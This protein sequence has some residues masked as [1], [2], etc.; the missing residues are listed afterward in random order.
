MA[1]SFFRE[2]RGVEIMPRVAGVAAWLR[3][4]TG[5][6]RLLV[7][8][9]LGAV[10]ALAYAP[11]YAWP[12]LFLAFPA[13][14]FIIDG[15]EGARR[16]WFAAGLGG[17][18]FGFG[19]FLVGL[20]WVG[21]AFVVDAERH[22]WLLPFVAVLFP[23]GLALFFAAAA[24]VARLRWSAG[25]AR[26]ALLAAC[27]AV[28]EWLRGHIL[29]GFPWNLPGYAWSGFDA[30]LQAASVFGV[31]GLSLLTLVAAL[32]PAAVFDA[33]GRRSRLAWPL[34]GPAAILVALFVFG[35]MRLPSVAAP[36]FPDV[37]LRIVQPNIPQ[38]EKWKPDLMERNWRTLLDLTRS[39]G[40]E[41]RTVVIWTEAAPPFLLLAEPLGLKVIAEVLPDRATLLTG[42]VR[43]EE[44]DGKRRFFNSMAAVSGEGRVLGVYDKSHLVPFGEYLPFYQWLEPLGI[45]K[46]TGGSGGYTQGSGVRT[47]AISGTPSFGPLICYEV[48]FPGAVIEPGHR[49]D[50]LVTMTDDSWFGPWTGPYQ[51][52]GIAKVRAAEEGLAI[53]RAAN[54]GVSAVIDPYGRIIS[55]LG[56]DKTGFL[57]AA[58]P[59]PLAPT[60]YSFVGDTIFAA[61]LL[62]LAGAGLFFYRSTSQGS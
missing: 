26:I 46:L 27:L 1:S 15:T 34:I 6:R 52:L 47:L 50:W 13:L 30:M 57:D 54:T 60:V 10:C 16:P 11:F 62:A 9:S 5:V 35:W 41:T 7:A 24:A 20:H 22:A 53:V 55:S 45:T 36:V 25:L 4:L 37:A 43:S 2:L 51:H 14:V 21:F 59:K 8:A 12:V 40:L 39:P 38:S 28:V 58:L 48:I 61:L 19:Y 56:L 18:A 3:R 31:Y 33:D 29:T 44:A 23:G 17:W 32:L 49:P 42:V